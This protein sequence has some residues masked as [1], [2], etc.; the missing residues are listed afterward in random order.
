LNSQKTEPFPQHP[1]YLDI[2][3]KKTEPNKLLPNKIKNGYTPTDEIN[4]TQT[5]RREI[6]DNIY[7]LSKNQKIPLNINFSL[8]NKLFSFRK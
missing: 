1:N 3:T 5:K 6:L 8:Q 4:D 2:F 7:P